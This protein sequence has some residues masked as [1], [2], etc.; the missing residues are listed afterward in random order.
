[1]APLTPSLLVMTGLVDCAVSIRAL[2][3]VMASWHS[4]VA[5]ARSKRMAHVVWRPFD[6]FSVALWCVLYLAGGVV[7]SA[8]ILLLDR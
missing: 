6:T 3:M 5:N 8:G 7:I 1:M 4:R 2:R